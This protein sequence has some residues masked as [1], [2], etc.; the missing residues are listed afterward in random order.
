MSNMLIEKDGAIFLYNS[1]LATVPGVNPIQFK[2]LEEYAEFTEWQ[3]S[4]DIKCPILYLQY[5][6]DTQNN[7][8]IQIKPSIFENHGG[9]PA[10]RIDKIGE[11]GDAYF[12]K[13]KMFDATKNST[14]DPNKKFNTNMYS[15]F[16]QYNQNVGLD[17]PLDKM[18][19]EKNNKSANPMDTHWGGKDYT[20]LKVAQGDYEGRYVRKHKP[21]K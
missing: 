2:D 3:A 1:D 16:D 17:T 4:Q 12:E 20:K 14:P 18:F 8:L 19:S 7:D 9:L 10:S 5:T 11:R 21:V 6:T 15:G 13:N